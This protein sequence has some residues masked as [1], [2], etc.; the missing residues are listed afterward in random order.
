MYIAG[1]DQSPEDKT[2][3]CLRSKDIPNGASS[4]L[5]NHLTPKLQGVTQ[6]YDGMQSLRQYADYFKCNV[7]GDKKQ[8]HDGLKKLSMYALVSNDGKTHRTVE[9]VDYKKECEPL[10]NKFLHRK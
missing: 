5:I 1:K 3:I 2:L 10:I 9:E 8:M 7:D 6:S 4:F